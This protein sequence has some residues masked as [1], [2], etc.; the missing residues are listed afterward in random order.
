MKKLKL[1]FLSVALAAVLSVGFG[2]GN[3]DSVLAAV[4]DVSPKAEACEAIGS[5]AD[6]KKAQGVNI[7]SVL[8][9]VINVFSVIIGIVAVIMIIISGFKYISSSGDTNKV[10]S[11]KNTIVYAIVGLIIVVCA[12]LIVQFVIK[13]V[14]T[15]PKRASLP[16][17]EQHA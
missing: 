6:C 17:L 13:G 8:T 11:A 5:G 10:A 4:G 2:L 7:D 15:A 9:I 16:V 12:Q 14:T 3:A 1:L